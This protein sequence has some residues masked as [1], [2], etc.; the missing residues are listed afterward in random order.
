VHA[1]LIELAGTPP[2]EV[3]L[4]DAHE[5][6]PTFEALRAAVLTWRRRASNSSA[7]RAS[8]R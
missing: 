5:I 7:S 3:R 8:A 1:Q 6:A 2:F 4:G